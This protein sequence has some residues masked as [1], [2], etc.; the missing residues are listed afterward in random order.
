MRSGSGDLIN[1][2]AKRPVYRSAPSCDFNVP[3]TT[4]AYLRAIKLYTHTHTHA[5]TH[6]CTHAHLLLSTPGRLSP[7]PCTYWHQRQAGCLLCP[8]L[9]GI[10]ASQTVSIPLYLLVPTPVKL[11]LYILLSMPIRLSPL[12]VSTSGRL[13]PLPCTYW[14]P[15]Q[16][17]CL[18][19]PVL[20]GIHASEV[21]FT[22]GTWS[23]A[24]DQR[25]VGQAI[26][27]FLTGVNLVHKT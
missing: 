21:F 10:N 1:H 14:Y 5:R 13:S 6:T 7:L 19:C 27:R 17:D 3:S 24:I 23:I 25:C 16:T 15:R 8:V 9:T 4:Q 2:R 18:P 12:L 26:L 11:C 20:T 22:T